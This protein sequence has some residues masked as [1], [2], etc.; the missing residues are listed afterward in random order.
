MDCS[1]PGSSVHGIFQATVQEWGATGFSGPYTGSTKFLAK[2]IFVRKMT[3]K[4]SK[5]NVL[6]IYLTSTC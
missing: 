5:S 6:A 4:V 1:L 3:L 2:I